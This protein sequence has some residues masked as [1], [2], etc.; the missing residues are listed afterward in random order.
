MPPSSDAVQVVA[1]MVDD[2][3]GRRDCGCQ[4]LTPLDWERA[5][6]DL[7]PPSHD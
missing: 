1:A 2:P 3:E 7:P 5:G 6:D 4:R